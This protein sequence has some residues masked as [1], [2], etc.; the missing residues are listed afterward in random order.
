MCGSRLSIQQQLASC[1]AFLMACAGPR[2]AFGST[3]ASRSSQRQRC[4][5]AMSSRGSVTLL[6]PERGQLQLTRKPLVSTLS[7]I[8]CSFR[9]P[10]AFNIHKTG[11]FT[12]L[13]A[14]VARVDA[15]QVQVHCQVCSARQ[16]QRQS[17][18]LLPL[19]PCS[20]RVARSRMQL[21]TRSSVCTLV[22][23]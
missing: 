9:Q 14:Y 6:A 8:H 16:Q 10:R 19:M 1:S 21:R 5:S 11:S 4:C 7:I 22:W 15:L 23:L 3:L 18:D 2:I 20:L 13:C 12:E 17:H